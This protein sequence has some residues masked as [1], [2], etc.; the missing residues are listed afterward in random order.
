MAD[1]GIFAIMQGE[2]CRGTLDNSYAEKEISLRGLSSADKNR[3][4]FKM[5]GRH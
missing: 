4:E 1:Y 5:D 3:L 2:N